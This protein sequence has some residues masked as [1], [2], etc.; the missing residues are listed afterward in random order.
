MGRARHTA[1]GR[2]ASHGSART[3]AP[4]ARLAFA[5]AEFTSLGGE[6]QERNAYARP[7]SPPSSDSDDRRR[8]RA[9]TRPRLC[10]HSQ[11]AILLVGRGYSR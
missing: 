8:H 7:H 6:R 9:G 5:A 10:N 1:G 11:L 4:R 2:R 3:P